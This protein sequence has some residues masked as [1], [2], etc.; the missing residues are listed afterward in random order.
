MFKSGK[1]S[2]K[3]WNNLSRT[4]ITRIASISS[5]ETGVRLGWSE[6]LPEADKVDFPEADL[7]TNALKA[8]SWEDAL[9]GNEESGK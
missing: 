7:D 2:V 6:A 3:L 9:G 1:A 8:S 5:F 4:C